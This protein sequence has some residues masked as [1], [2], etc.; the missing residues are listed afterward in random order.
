MASGVLTSTG[1]ACGSGGGGSG[2]ATTSPWTNG[3]LAYVTGLGT[4]GSVA[5]G[6]LTETVTG[7]EFNATRGLVGGA[8]I[9]AITSGYGIPLTASTTEWSGFYNTPSTRIT[10]GTGLSWSG[11]TLNAT[12]GSGGDTAWATTT[13][14]DGAVAQYPIT[15][16]VDILF[17]GSS[18]STASFWFDKSATTT[19][20]G[21]GGAGDSLI[22]LAIAGV[23]KWIFG[24]DDSDSDAFVISS[25]SALGTSNKAR[26]TTATTTL[27]NTVTEISDGTNGLRITPGS[28][29]T[30]LTFF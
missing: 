25:G 15:S 20:L 9:L 3:D 8:A 21:N 30:T 27:S 22:E 29:T 16:T 6:T 4:V 19:R 26:I 28:S 17:G 18:T 14:L 23:S 7:L 11:N 12:S 10:A 2:L 24:A 5:T 13:L 1:S